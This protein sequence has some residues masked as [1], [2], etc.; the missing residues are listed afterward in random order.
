MFQRRAMTRGDTLPWVL[1]EFHWLIRGALSDGS[2][3][4]DY[5]GMR[6]QRVQ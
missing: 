3:V 6:E 5:Q 2:V 1:L 4:K